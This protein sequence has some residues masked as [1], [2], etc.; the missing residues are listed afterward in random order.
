MRVVEPSLPA[1]Y[2]PSGTEIRFLSWHT[3]T[4][5]LESAPNYWLATTYPDGR[6]HVV[7]RWG[8]WIDDRFWYDGSPDTRHVRN[9][10]HNSACVLHLESGTRVVIVH[11]R[12]QRS[13][14]VGPEFGAV[15]SAEF[16]RKYGPLGYNPP[17]DSWSDSIA[18]GLR[19][20]FPSKVLGWTEFPVDLTKFE[21]D[22]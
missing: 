4:H 15:L 5:E 22:A 20:V 11:G 12:S 2:V 21:L 14:P 18:G 6:P 10:E 7:P 17:P 19:I 8:V 9:L 1:G 16:G 13:D 3:V